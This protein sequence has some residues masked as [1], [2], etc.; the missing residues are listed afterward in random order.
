M[1]KLLALLFLSPL[2]HAE[3]SVSD[4]IVLVGMKGADE[5]PTIYDCKN[6]SDCL[7]FHGDIAEGDY[8]EF[9][10]NLISKV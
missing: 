7:Y 8:I 3:F 2:V 6:R 5:T 9:E 10:K 4:K 1:K